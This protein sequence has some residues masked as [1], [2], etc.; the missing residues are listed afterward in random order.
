MAENWQPVT[1]TKNHRQALEV[2][3]GDANSVDADEAGE[4]A[5]ATEK[6]SQKTTSR[7]KR[8]E[9][10]DGDAE[11]R[12][13]PAEAT[14]RQP[15]CGQWQSQGETGENAAEISSWLRMPLN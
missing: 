10:K 2:E 14:T 1:T 5:P 9:T 12:V 6:T 13:N 8:E 3:T 15:T 4:R 7:K 11:P